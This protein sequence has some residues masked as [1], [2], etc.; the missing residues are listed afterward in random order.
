MRCIALKYTFVLR[1]TDVK[2]LR[3]VF[4]FSLAA[5]SLLLG[6]CSNSA[7]YM[8][9]DMLPVEI[10]NPISLYLDLAENRYNDNDWRKE[11]LSQLFH[12]N[13]N[14]IIGP[15]SFSAIQEKLPQLLSGDRIFT[16][17]IIASV[18]HAQERV[19][20]SAPK[21]EI[22]D[23]YFVKLTY[24][25]IGVIDKNFLSLM[26]KPTKVSEYVVLAED[27]PSGKY[28]IIDFY[29]NGDEY[30]FIGA[31]YVRK[32]AKSFILNTE[33]IDTFNRILKKGGI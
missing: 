1:G 30:S 27:K 29:P 7:K 13:L 11:N 25:L 26:D 8:T 31:E 4:I 19:D 17:V 2:N 5:L 12:S 6:G 22:Q 23:A 9:V 21:G 18:S 28:K 16:K 3:K 15:R 10:R 24:T 33:I 32:N 14:F 20:H